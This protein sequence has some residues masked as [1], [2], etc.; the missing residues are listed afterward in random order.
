M[1]SQEL[2]KS[3]ES[4]GFCIGIFQRVQLRTKM[5]VS[6]R[7]SPPLAQLTNPPNTAGK[8]LG[9]QSGIGLHATKLLLGLALCVWSI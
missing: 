9:A 8:M 5:N 1:T 2:G 4:R 7:N 3:A 6:G